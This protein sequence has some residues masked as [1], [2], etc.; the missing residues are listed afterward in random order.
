VA[1]VKNTV[2]FQALETHF[3]VSLD[4]PATGATDVPGVPRVTLVPG[5]PPGLAS[6]VEG[7]LKILERVYVT[8]SEILRRSNEFFVDKNTQP[9]D[10]TPAQTPHQGSF[11]QRVEVD[12][13]GPV[14]LDTNQR[15]IEILHPF[16]TFGPLSQQF[17]L[18]HEAAHFSFPPIDHFAREFPGLA[19][20]PYSTDTKFKVK[21]TKN[22][23]QLSFSEAASNA[24]SYAQ[25][26]L[27]MFFRTDKRLQK[28]GG[29][30]PAGHFE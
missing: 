17:V 27:H 2:E 15:V 11:T 5:L 8:I 10:P 20:E 9:N 12:E 4:A 23:A 30:P 21:R 18:L 19:G 1:N 26:A 6:G 24:D 14:I 28:V 25:C 22:Y 3:H 7:R 13:I 16:P 29:S